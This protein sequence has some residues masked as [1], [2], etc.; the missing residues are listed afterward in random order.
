[1]PKLK[2]FPSR[3]GTKL[4]STALHTL[5]QQLLGWMKHDGSETSETTMNFMINSHPGQTIAVDDFLFS[6]LQYLLEAITGTGWHVCFETAVQSRSC[7]PLLVREG[8]GELHVGVTI[9]WIQPLWWFLSWASLHSRNWF[10]KS[11]ILFVQFCSWQCTCAMNALEVFKRGW[12]SFVGPMFRNYSKQPQTIFP[13]KSVR[14]ILKIGLS[15]KTKTTADNNTT[16]LK[17]QALNWK[18][19]WLIYSDL[20]PLCFCSISFPT[21]F[22]QLFRSWFQVIVF[23]R[24]WKPK[25]MQ[26]PRGMR[27]RVVLC[28][29]LPLTASGKVG[30]NPIPLCTVEFP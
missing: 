1:M 26:V 27:P 25:V 17:V 16:I 20:S 9:T 15:V 10:P 11:R 7:D 30:T 29:S 5:D 3:A 23:T 4:G 13:R 22:S 2:D 18:A 6:Q 28:S 12:R 24:W 19:T 14:P 21:K 8:G